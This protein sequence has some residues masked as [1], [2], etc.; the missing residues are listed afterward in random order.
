MN[1]LGY[2]FFFNKIGAESQ[3]AVDRPTERQ[4]CEE[5]IQ[6]KVRLLSFIKLC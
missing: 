3:E 5:T 1:A 4:T 2:I 6:Q